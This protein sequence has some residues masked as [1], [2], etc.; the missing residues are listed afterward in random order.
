[1]TT[2][3][4]VQTMREVTIFIS[5]DAATEEQ[6]DEIFDA[7]VQSAMTKGEEMGIEDVFAVG[8]LGSETYERASNPFDK[9]VRRALADPGAF[10]KR[11][12]DRDYGGW[13]RL[14][15][16]QARAVHTVVRRYVAL[17]HAAVAD[18]YQYLAERSVYEPVPAR[19]VP[20]ILSSAALRGMG[21]EP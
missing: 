21:L 19:T 13:E 16:W 15:R 9:E 1:M 17:A 18:E 2:S 5:P 8:S 4:P 3:D 6:A 14:D 7:A 20:R 11:E 10:V 12:P